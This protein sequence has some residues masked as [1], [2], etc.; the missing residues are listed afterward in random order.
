M[1]REFM[2][3]EFYQDHGGRPFSDLV[4]LS[5]GLES[6]AFPGQD[7][8]EVERLLHMVGCF[9]L[10]VNDLPLNIELIHLGRRRRWANWS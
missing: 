6:A 8:K 5:S 7:E 4:I 2:D 9:F 3:C 10:S 1:N